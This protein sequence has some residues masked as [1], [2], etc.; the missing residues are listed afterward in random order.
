MPKLQPTFTVGDWTIEPDLLEVRRGET[1]R[2]LEPKVMDL[3]VCLSSRAP[4]VVSRSEILEDVWDGRVVVDETVTRAVSLLRQAFGDDAQNPSY[5]E[6]IP[7]KGYRLL[8][9]VE[10]Q[11]P[12]LDDGSIDKDKNDVDVEEDKND[13]ART[14]EADLVVGEDSVESPGEPR[15]KTLRLGV[16][17]AVA[18]VLSALLGAVLAAKLGATRVAE[19]PLGSLSRP[20]DSNT[21]A[22]NDERAAIAVLPFTAA[23][24]DGV[25][26]DG[27]T[28]ELI[29]LLSR[30]PD[31]RVVSRTSSMRF[32]DSSLPVEDIARTLRVD[33]LLEGSVLAIGGRVRIHAQLVRPAGDETLLSERYEQDLVDVLSLQRDVARDVAQEIRV[34]LN[35]EEWLRKGTADRVDPEAYRLYLRASS[36]L[37]DR[38]DMSLP[39]SLFERSVA[40]DP[41]FS[42]AWAG[43]AEA[44]L[45]GVQYLSRPGGH[46]RAADAIAKALDLDDHLAQAHAAKGLLLLSRDQDWDASERSFQRAIELA[47]SDSTAYQWY[48]EMLSLAGRHEEAVDKVETALDLDPL[49]PL[50]HAAAGQRLAAA[51]R[52]EDAERELLAADELG[53]PFAWHLRELALVRT[54]LGDENGAIEARRLQMQRKRVP[55]TDL[56]AFERAVA[57][58]GMR[59][60]WRWYRSYLDATDDRFPM[61]R[62]EAAAALGFDAEAL[63]WLEPTLKD[64]ALWFLHTQRS[65]AFDSL[66]QDP[67]FL[68]LV[69][70]YPLWAPTS[71]TS[72]SPF[73][74][75]EY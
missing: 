39:V 40:I 61:R 46:E 57:E 29:H 8:V 54:R 68:E 55:E 7:T 41:N 34:P 66:R 44:E 72:L 56:E 11:G 6:T 62:A 18:V 45:L 60:F 3:L 31:L 33:Y 69:A 30:M 17:I 21:T 32:R 38:L 1:S 42:L 15:S 5:I 47:P 27:L 14:G 36:L 23:P 51:E 49:S 19:S 28:D 70:G 37:K 35:S 58:S 13:E 73:G 22:R 2:R 59:G 4:Q 71:S 50:V 25:L 75:V 53:A 65:P 26:A 20:F 24:D 67:R 12:E 64:Q 9:A 74:A 52:Y 10:T 63:A 43:L 48:S 16:G